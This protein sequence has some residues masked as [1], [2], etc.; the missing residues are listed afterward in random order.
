MSTRKQKRKK[1]KK[2]QTVD[3]WKKKQWFEVYAPKSFK[4]MYIGLIPANDPKYLPNRTM[5]ALLYDL[6]NNFAHQH[7]KIRFKIVNSQG[8]KAYAHF[9]GHEYTRAKVRSM[10][11]PRTSAINSI[12]NYKTKDN[13]I[14]R[15]SVLIV[16]QKQAKQSQQKAIRRIAHEV[17]TKFAESTPHEKFINGIIYGR[18]AKN[19]AKIAKTIYPLYHCEIF[20]SKVISFPDGIEDMYYEDEEIEEIDVDLGE[21]G[22]TVK[23]LK[24]QKDEKEEKTE[25]EIGENEDA[26]LIEEA[27]SA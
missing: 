5:E 12:K 1:K 24:K 22:K 3:P 2:R 18:Y 20:K 27:T 14:Y 11:Q 7:I 17:L 16:T 19:I 13:F 26:E 8:D 25:D 4:E 6:T 9:F 23:A 15:V 10:I 21:H